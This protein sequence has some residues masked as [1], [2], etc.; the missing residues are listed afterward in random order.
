MKKTML[1]EEELQERIDKYI[2]DHHSE[3]MLQI[4]K[5]VEQVVKASLRTA[6]ATG[7]G[8]KDEKGWARSYVESLIDPKIKAAINVEDIHIDTDD[9]RNKV[10]KSVDTQIKKI[11]V[12]VSL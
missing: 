8:Y 2:A 1:T 4:D 6:F 3:V 9:I 11:S 7:D 10:M 5:H 12:K